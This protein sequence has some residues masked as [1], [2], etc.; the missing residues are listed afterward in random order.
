[1]NYNIAI[2]VPEPLTHCA[3]GYQTQTSVA[4]RVAAVR[5]LTQCAMVETPNILSKVRHLFQNVLVMFNENLG[6]LD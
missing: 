5:F 1:M 2:A 4:V 6:F 3:G